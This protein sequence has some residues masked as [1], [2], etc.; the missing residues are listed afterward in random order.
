MA[1]SRESN[2]YLLTEKQN[3][4]FFAAKQMIAETSNTMANLM[5]SF[6]ACSGLF[7]SAKLPQVFITPI[8]KNK[9]NKA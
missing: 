1:S 9:T 8:T 6:N 7:I 4:T 3:M 5:N 2:I